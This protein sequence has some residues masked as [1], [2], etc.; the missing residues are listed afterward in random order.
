MFRSIR[1][2][3]ITGIIVI[4]PLGVTIFVINLLIDKLGR[5][6]SRFFF[7]NLDVAPGSPM[8]KALALLAVIIVFALI[9]LI[10]YGSRF[11]IGR[12]LLN[13]FEQLLHRVPLIN[14]VYGTVKQ[15]VTTFSEQ[16]K[17]VFQEV[18]LLEYPRKNCYVLGFLTSEAKGEPQAVTGEKIVNIFVPTTPNPTSGF[19][20]ML[21]ENDITRLTMS[22]ADG[23]KVIISG[24]AVTPPHSDDPVT[25]QN[26]E[27]AQAEV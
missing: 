25:I 26:P 5:P 16:K 27:E 6:A 17:A 15:I 22:V 2:A 4:L 12:V 14:T 10:G 8:D 23:M 21:P 1:N 11:V 20:L 24:G 7:G 9:T 3:F 18:V 13:F 19:L